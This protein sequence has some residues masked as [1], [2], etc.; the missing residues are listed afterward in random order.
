MKK[1]EKMLENKIKSEKGAITALV[2][3]SLLIMAM[4]FINLYMMQ[5]NKISSQDKE[6]KTI[7]ET[8]NISGEELSNLYT[9]VKENVRIKI[10]ASTIASDPELYYGK[11]VADYQVEGLKYRVFFIDLNNKYG[12]GT[13]TIYLIADDVI[14]MDLNNYISYE[15]GDEDL[16]KYK[17]M[18]PIWT[19]QRGSV[20]I[21]DWNISEKVASWVASP[22]QWKNYANDSKAMY[23]IGAP[24]I[25]MYVDSYNQVNHTIGNN[26]FE[27]LYSSDKPGYMYK[28]NGEFQEEN[29][30]YT[31][32]YVLDDEGYNA[33][34]CNH[35]K[36]WWVASP[37]SKSS[38]A[39][40]S[41]KG[42]GDH[43]GYNYYYATDG[44]KPLV[45]LKAGTSIEVYQYR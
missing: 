9:E 3:A 8:Y 21:S 43:L 30:L 33:M 16:I 24:S 15:P 36:I 22:S 17:N 1:R 26:K 6:L 31:S 34:Y 12:D 5:S 10:N 7:Q 27:L 41:V 42:I 39:L 25:E 35:K 20:S 45:A 14:T 37:S 11:E 38:K 13:N 40:C 23:A 32:D 2:L 18:N 44:L 19:A 4:V 29:G 28:V